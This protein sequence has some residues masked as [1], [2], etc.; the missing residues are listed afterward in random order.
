MLQPSSAL[1]SSASALLNNSRRSHP[2]S[3]SGMELAAA[4]LKVAKLAWEAA[5]EM[6]EASPGKLHQPP[7]AAV[8]TKGLN[9]FLHLHQ[10]ESPSLRHR[11]QPPTPDSADSVGVPK[12]LRTLLT[13]KNPLSPLTS[14]SA[15]ND[16]PSLGLPPTFPSGSG[17]SDPSQLTIIPGIPLWHQRNRRE[18][19]PGIDARRISPAEPSPNETSS[20]RRQIVPGAPPQPSMSSRSSSPVTAASPSG[21]STTK[22]ATTSVRSVALPTVATRPEQRRIPSLASPGVHHGG[23]DLPAANGGEPT[24][25]RRPPQPKLAQQTYSPAFPP[26]PAAMAT[27]N[28]GCSSFPARPRAPAAAAHLL[29]GVPKLAAAVPRQLRRP[30]QNRQQPGVPRSSVDGTHVPPTVHDSTAADPQVSSSTS[31]RSDHGDSKPSD[32]VADVPPVPPLQTLPPSRPPLPRRQQPKAAP[33]LPR[34]RLPLPVAVSALL[35]DPRQAHPP[36]WFRS[37]AL[38]V[39]A[40]EN[41]SPSASRLR[42]SAGG[43]L[44]QIVEAL[45]KGKVILVI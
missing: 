45:S 19:S 5:N 25:P 40:M 31:L 36:L 32:P 3:T 29:L 17:S 11:R 15:R 33:G 16:K 23:P 14:A 18:A 1:A 9:C 8:T 34:S 7:P 30:S 12:K 10:A 43:V 27:H 41:P 38:V 37:P 44:S 2:L 28:G 24:S 6:I 35:D 42:L 22:E 20:Q 26:A 13:L 21:P 4:A 39:A